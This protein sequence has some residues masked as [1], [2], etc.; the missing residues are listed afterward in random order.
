MSH[1]CQWRCRFPG[2]SGF[3]HSVPLNDAAAIA[4]HV[5]NMDLHEDDLWAELRR[6]NEVFPAPLPS[7][8]LTTG[9]RLSYRRA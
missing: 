4:V 1:L 8:I 6:I 9:T 7:Q 5:Q 2:T 3:E